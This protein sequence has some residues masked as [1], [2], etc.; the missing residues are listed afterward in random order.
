V[1]ERQS[2]L[3]IAVAVLIVM[4]LVFGLAV[5]FIFGPYVSTW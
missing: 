1:T 4:A 5:V 3:L 2:E